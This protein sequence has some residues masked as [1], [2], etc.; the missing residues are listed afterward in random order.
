MKARLNREK[1]EAALVAK[2]TNMNRVSI[3]LDIP[4]PVICNWKNGRH[5]PTLANALR[6]CALLDVD[7]RDLWTVCP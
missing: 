4:P 5:G 2:G 3:A 1:F 7:P 6:L